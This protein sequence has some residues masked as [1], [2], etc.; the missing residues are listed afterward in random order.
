M[1]D[2][3]A[4]DPAP[5]AT[6]RVFDPA[7]C[8]SS[9]VCGPDPDAEL[10]RFSGDLAWL[11]RQGVSVRRYNLGQEP[12]A[13]AAD[14][15]VRRALGSRGVGCLPLVFVGDRLLGEGAYPSRATLAEVLFGAVDS[16][17]APSG[18]EGTA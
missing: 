1:T 11:A 6:V 15:A 7:L 5:E 16:L 12:G 9:G 14:P 4:R 2:L 10:I 17:V 13:F 18:A 3:L 8:C